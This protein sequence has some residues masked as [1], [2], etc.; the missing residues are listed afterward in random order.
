LKKRNTIPPALAQKLLISFLKDDLAEEVLGDLEQ[1][2]YITLKT[3]SPLKAKLNY[4]YQVM[5]YMRP[6]AIRKLKSTPSNNIAMFQ[7]YFKIG[8]RN[9]FKEKGYSFINIGG[10]AAGMAVAVLRFMDL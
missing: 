1:K 5:H 7:S 3:K 8:W 9:L 10:L 6:F 2:F 4:W